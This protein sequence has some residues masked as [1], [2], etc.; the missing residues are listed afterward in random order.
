MDS[1]SS[2]LHSNT[3]ILKFIS[4]LPQVAENSSA[5]SATPVLPT[6]DSSIGTPAAESTSLGDA[7][8]KFRI[9]KKGKTGLRRLFEMFLSFPIIA[10]AP[11]PLPEILDEPSLEEP[12]IR[13]T[14]PAAHE[15]TY[16][17]VE[18]G[19]RQQHRKLIDSRGYS[20]NV[21]RRTKTAVIWQCTLRKGHYC[22]AVVKEVDGAF[23]ETQVHDHQP[24]V[25]AATAAKVVSAVK[26]KALENVFKPAS[27]IVQEVYMTSKEVIYNILK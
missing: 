1:P 10:E 15:V 22:K 3:V 18:E 24:A 14:E 25:G 21:K 20:Y 4:D 16:E 23:H 6:I 26:R 17:I 5:A 11:I 8:G 27:A 13:E 7:D 12:S 19:S 2:F 9:T